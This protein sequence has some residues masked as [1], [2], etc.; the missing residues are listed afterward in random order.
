MY[1]NSK[2]RAERERER[3]RGAD[4]WHSLEVWGP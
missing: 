2:P 4:L 3:E 1:L